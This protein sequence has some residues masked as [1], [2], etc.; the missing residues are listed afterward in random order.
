MARKQL[1][2]YLNQLDIKKGEFLEK[3]RN[4]YKLDRFQKS[5][6]ILDKASYY[7]TIP[8]EIISEIELIF[9]LMPS[10]EL[11]YIKKDELQFS[12]YLKQIN[13]L[14]IK[15]LDEH[16]KYNV[17][18]DNFIKTLFNILF[19][20]LFLLILYHEKFEKWIGL[21]FTILFSILI[22]LI[23]LYFNRKKLWNSYSEF[24]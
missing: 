7:F 9:Q 17:Q 6:E 14:F 10:H 2:K 8:D 5:L 20:I 13:A 18:P 22:S 23:L 19:P 1:E 4:E 21:E 11:Y 15:V 12:E 3:Q 24:V 16:G